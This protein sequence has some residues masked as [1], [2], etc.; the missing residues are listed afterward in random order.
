LP[1]FLDMLASVARTDPELA[2]RALAGLKIYGD[3][4]RVIMPPRQALASAGRARLLDG[5]GAGPAVV[6]VPSLINPA[7]V[8]DLDAERSL[9]GHLARNGYRSLLVDWGA[10]DQGE[11]GRSIADH[12]TDLLLPLIATVG[13]PVHLIG[14]C[15]GGTMAVAA[16]MHCEPRSL[17]LLAAPWHFSRYPEQA[18]SQLGDLWQTH[19]STV[20]RMGLAPI[21]L[22]QTAFWGLDP[23]RTIGKFAALA[24]RA[25]DD[26]VAI[27]FAALEDWAN[28]GAPLTAMAAHDLFDAFVRDDTTGRGRWRVGGV[29]VDPRQLK[30]PALNL[31]AHDDR[32]APAATAVDSIR[33]VACPS[34]HVGMIVGRQS[35]R[36]CR[37]FL[38]DWLAQQ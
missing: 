2:R 35:E 30:C 1:L 10:P 8:L 31:V 16:A 3:A 27:G 4:P 18:R 13:E 9:L 34:G 15:L 22:L 7:A 5:G 36:G 12:V 33:T 28:D 21:E 25:A 17:T 24:G 6:L 14:Y 23:D 20:D 38:L 26:P 32:I 29:D 19:R 37:F 11:A